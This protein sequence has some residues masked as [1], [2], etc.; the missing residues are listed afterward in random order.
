M[1]VSFKSCI[2]HPGSVSRLVVSCSNSATKTKELEKLKK[3]LKCET[4]IHVS[5][6]EIAAVLSLA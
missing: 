2:R 3:M 1:L 4:P 5:R 6:W